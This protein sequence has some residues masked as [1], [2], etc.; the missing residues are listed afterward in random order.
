MLFRSNLKGAAVGLDE[1][2]DLKRCGV[3]VEGDPVPCCF[4]TQADAAHT[5]H[6]VADVVEMR[7]EGEPAGRL[8]AFGAVDMV[9]GE[10]VAGEAESGSAI[11]EFLLEE[12]AK[13]PGEGVAGGVGV[14]ELDDA[15]ELSF[16]I[17]FELMELI[18]ERTEGARIFDSEARAG[19][20]LLDALGEGFAAEDEGLRMERD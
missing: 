5:D 2:L 16:G 18:E 13:G 15:D 17:E 12:G 7:A 9:S 14:P 1:V 10:G 11:A 20:G 8:R 3:G 6:G 4:G 19:E